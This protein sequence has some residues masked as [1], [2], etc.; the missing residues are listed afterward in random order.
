MADL[1][2]TA[3]NVRCSSTANTEIR[4]LANTAAQGKALYLLADGTAGLA[5]SNAAAPAN[6]FYGFSMTSGTAGQ[7]V[8]IVKAD[9]S[10]YT[11]GSTLAIGPVYLSNTAG[12]ITQT[13]AD[14]ASGTTLIQVG[15]ALTTTTMNLNSITGGT[16]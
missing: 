6:S 8:V 2:I 11:P 1:T 5:D 15:A 12:G 16:V 14:L 3:A 13:L 9:G 7:P 4:I 10:G